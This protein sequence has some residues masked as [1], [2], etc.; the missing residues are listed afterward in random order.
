MNRK[1]TSD[2]QELWGVLPYRKK[3]N[4]VTPGMSNK[5]V[6]KTNETEDDIISQWVFPKREPTDHQI[7]LIAGRVS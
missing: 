2:L 1:Y 6:N 3:V 7:R 4:G 5:N